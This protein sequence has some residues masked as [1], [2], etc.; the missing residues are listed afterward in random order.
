MHTPGPEADRFVF[1]AS[2][3]QKRLWFL[4]R[5]EPAN[6][7]YNVPVGLRLRVPLQTRALEEALQE[8]VRRHEALRTTLETREG[9]PVQVVAADLRVPLAVVDLQ[10]EAPAGR[11]AAAR[12]AADE[13][14]RR[15]FDLA[16]GP[17]LRATLVRL[18]PDDHLLLL[19]LHHVVC[20]G[21]S[22]GVLLRELDHLYAALARGT[23][24]ALPDLPVQYA[25]F[26]AWQGEWLGGEVLETQLAYWRRQLHDLPT[27]RLPT[28][29]PRPP[30]QSFRGARREVR[31]PDPLADALKALSRRE[32]VTLFMTLLAGFQALLHRYTGQGDVVVGAPIA[33]RSRE[34]VEGLIGFFT[35]T[36][37]LRTDLSGDPT[38]RD[39]L[40]RVR[41]VALG[42]YAH[43]DVPFELLVEKLQPERDLGRN[44][45][46][47]VAF[48]F[49]S[50]TTLPREVL[51]AAPEWV[52]GERG[53]AIFDLTV[54]LAE[55]R[56]GVAG[57]VEYSTALF[58]APTVE[59]LW[60]H[61]VTLLEGAAADP[62]RRLSELP[63]L[64]E[65]ERQQLDAFNATGADFPGPDVLHRL[66][67]GQAGRTPDA[68]A[69]AAPEGQLSF[70][71]L[72]RRANRLANYL[73]RHGVGPDVLV[74]VCLDRS[75]DLVVALL[76]VLKAGGAYV[77]LDP[78]YPAERLA[79][80]LADARAPVLVTWRRF[81]DRL[82]V[83]G[84]RVLCLDGDG[85]AVAAESD[86]DPPGGVTGGDLAY[87]IYTSGST[88]TPKGAMNTHRGIC[89]RLRWGQDA[90]PLTAADCVL[91]KT[92]FGF[93]VSVW[94]FFWPLVAGARLVVAEPGGHRDPRYLAGVIAREEVTTLHFVPSMLQAFLEEPGPAACPSVRQVTCSGEA[95]PVAL[96]ERFFARFA[97]ALH[98]LYGPTEAAVEV[99]SWACVRGDRRRSVPIGRPIANTRLH[100]LDASLR[101]VPVGVPGELFLGGA[102]VGRGYWD[103]P[104][105]TAERFVPDPSGGEPGARLYRT[106]DLARYG[107]DGNV[108][109]LGR[110]DDQVKVRGFRIEP[111]EVAA[112]LGRHPAVQ[113]AVVVAREDKGGDKRLVAYLVPDARTAFARRPSAGPAPANGHPAAGEAPDPWGGPGR[114]VG[115]VRGYLRERLPE[116][117]VPGAFVLLPELPLNPNG[118]VD[119]KALPPPGQERAPEGDGF[120][121]PRDGPERR[122]CRIW[123]E[124]LGTR[125][126]G[127]RDN[128]F[129][130]GGHSLLAVR[131]FTRVEQEFR[132][133]LPLATLFRGP[134]VEELARALAGGEAPGPWSCL[135]PLQPGGTLPPFY[136]VHAIDG[137]VFCYG[138][139]ARELGPD[140]PFYGLRAWGL[141]GEVAPH[142]RVEEMAAHYLAEV[143]R[144]QP[145]GPYYLG[146][147]SSGALIALEMAHQLAAGGQ[148][149]GLL[150]C[151]DRLPVNCGP[152]R[153]PGSRRLL[154]NF[155]RNLV[156]W[157]DDFL[158][159]DRDVQLARFRD[160][161]RRLFNGLARP[162]L[163]PPQH[164]PQLA[165]VIEE[166][167]SPLPE[168]RREARRRFLEEHDRAYRAYRPRPYPGR[169]TLFSAT[170]RALFS[171]EDPAGECGPVAA[172]GV[173]VRVVPGS[174]R[175]ILKPPH[176]RA[177][178]RQLRTALEV[179]RAAGPA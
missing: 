8:V 120:V 124:L 119:R 154:A 162:F 116:Y 123:E 90:H 130:L 168:H 62:S 149:V 10:G 43:Q 167:V 99:T 83:A 65:P 91:Q 172:G 148:G 9:E 161:V 85:A 59:R 131:L 17:L 76:G 174:H 72:N 110:L 60:G 82:P 156:C 153:R 28:D 39:V 73:C 27:L 97:A 139:L 37:V 132:R 33:G 179:A 163:G 31:L 114:L 20:D 25:D 170:R 121:A 105:L 87:V 11:D 160:R 109:F 57:G 51:G 7:F 111:G 18:A 176:V 144:L 145:E 118:K 169:I 125:P 53:A 77:P 63:L 13:E 113:E 155:V 36:L 66:V 175:G 52:P 146:G 86:A 67:E 164:S 151:L 48:Q 106:G 54:S 75:L 78:G 129:D 42:A 14:A 177:L 68:V 102:G 171:V 127:V 84:P 93:D 94:E 49:F 126:V 5:L 29:H 173:E 34:E 142:A 6:P 152:R 136:C 16:A 122:L 30:V 157:A 108:E 22:V 140:Q 19:T 128:F 41:E 137:D 38:F 95:L 107:P 135:V 64:T 24:P 166:W 12:R 32:G 56:E 45:L 40:G 58:E 80:M 4:H 141:E 74:G 100:V 98:N 134:T 26:T 112:V 44:P 165:G 103:R 81:R 79:F 46:F 138:E 117:A 89:N 50:L 147:F 15:P 55:A 104:G 88:G 61:Y 2:H 92:P 101:P 70:G 23:A 178:A 158:R 21:W 133:H 96:Q 3:A 143:R 159:T 71:E 35:N 115:D 47:Q 1:P 150:A 69:V